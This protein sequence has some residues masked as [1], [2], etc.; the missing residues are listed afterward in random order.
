[1]ACLRS[2]AAGGRLTPA[3]ATGPLLGGL[4]GRTWTLMWPGAPPRAYALTAAAAY[5]AVTLR[6]TLTAIA[7]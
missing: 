3:L 6:A 4:T 5:L 2:G 1:M 7:P